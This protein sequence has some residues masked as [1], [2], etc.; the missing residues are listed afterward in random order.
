MTE[1]TGLNSPE[2]IAY[3]R[4]S[5]ESQGRS[6][7][8]LAAQKTQVRSFVARAG[9][10]IIREYT[11]I[12]SGKSTTRPELADALTYCRRSKATLLV[13]KI[14]RLA[15]NL[16]FLTSIMDSGVD[17]VACD[18]PTANRLTI[19]IMAAMAEHEREMISTRTKQGLAE[20]K[21]N[22]VLLGSN[23]PGFWTPER[24]ARRV[25]GAHKA[26]LAAAKSHKR[27]AARAYDDIL[28]MMRKWRAGGDTLELIADKLNALKYKTRKGNQWTHS[29][30][31][32]VLT[33][34]KPS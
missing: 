20:A 2:Y 22:G 26:G 24:H 16:H 5:T 3:Y 28:P 8:G 10:E 19:H 6:G 33:R 13:A 31:R 27:R 32:N 23:R 4:V 30:V 18:M 17:F 11:E 34:H 1:P 15:R 14:D 21:K 9:G 29:S 25:E 12:E 7:L